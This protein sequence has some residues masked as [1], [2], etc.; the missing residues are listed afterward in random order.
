MLN[1]DFSLKLLSKMVQ[2]RAI[3]ELIANDFLNNKIFSFLHLSIGQES[4]AVGVCSALT[5]E[6]LVMGNHRSHHHYLA[7]GG[8]LEKM[9]YEIYGDS[10]GCCKGFGGSMHMLDRSV[11]FV[12]STPILGSVAPLGTGIGFS[13]KAS[14]RNNIAVVFIGDGAAEEGA[15]YESI[16]LAALFKVPLLFV[17][18][19]NKYSVISSHSDRKSKDYSYSK[20]IEGL[21]ATY[22]N[23]EAKDVSAVHAKTASLK[24]GIL[25]QRKPAVLHLDVVR[26]VYGHSGPLK[27]NAPHYRVNDNVDFITANDCIG[28]YK[29]KLVLEN[30]IETE[31]IE[32]LIADKIAEVETLFFNVRNNIKIRI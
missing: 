3:E 13:L 19:D 29:D 24:E 8:D 15:F 1:S 12:G 17:I 22:V 26:G 21:G 6:D 32:T 11:G 20:I 18:E 7:K 10:R 28:F 9:I 25:S 14:N 30:K 16:N 31:A 23:M 27:E 5:T 4:A 2:I